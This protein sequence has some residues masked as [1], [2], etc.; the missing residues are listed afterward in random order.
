MEPESTTSLTAGALIGPRGGGNAARVVGRAAVTGLLSLVA[1]LARLGFVCEL[2]PRPILI[3]FLARTRCTGAT[4][5][6]V[7]PGSRAFLRTRPRLE[8]RGHRRPAPGFI[9][10]A[11]D[12]PPGD[13]LVAERL[14]EAL[15]SDHVAL[16]NVTWDKTHRL[17]QRLSARQIDVVRAGGR[18]PEHA[19]MPAGCGRGA[20]ESAA[21][22]PYVLIG[23]SRSG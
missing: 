10:T 13:R 11:D 3:G 4:R 16:R 6:W 7:S 18:I 12:P 9:S 17:R 8:P 20:D 5:H 14:H 19:A 2:L 15:D 1:W 23:T 21:S 22:S